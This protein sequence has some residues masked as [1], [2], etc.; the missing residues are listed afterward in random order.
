MSVIVPEKTPIKLND[1]LLDNL[2]VSTFKLKDMTVDSF[3]LDRNLSF[4]D[5]EGGSLVFEMNIKPSVMEIVK[6]KIFSYNLVFRNPITG[7]TISSHVVSFYEDFK[8]IIDVGES[9]HQ[10][11]IDEM[12]KPQSIVVESSLSSAA[13]DPPQPL[14]LIDKETS[15]PL[16]FPESSSLLVDEGLDPD[17][18][19]Q[20]SMPKFT[21][22]S[23][24]YSLD[25]SGEKTVS[26]YRLQK[27]KSYTTRHIGE[28][29]SLVSLRDERLDQITPKIKSPT[30][31]SHESSAISALPEPPVDSE[32]VDV[33]TR[34]E[35]IT[36][37]FDS[38]RIIEIPKNK[39][40][41]GI[42]DAIFTPIVSSSDGSA[43]DPDASVDLPYE[44]IK[45]TIRLK[46]S[47]KLPALLEPEVP[48][49]ILIRSNTPGKISYSVK[50]NDPTTKKILVTA[51]HLNKYTLT[52]LP[53]SDKEFVF[54]F[55]GYDGDIK[56]GVFNGCVNKDPYAVLLIAQDI[57]P[58]GTGLASTGAIAKSFPS[59]SLQDYK[60]NFVSV[61]A[62]LEPE[63]NVRIEIDQDTLQQ[64]SRIKICRENLSVPVSSL[65]RTK[66]LLDAAGPSKTFTHLD[67]TPI[68]NKTYRYY[69]VSEYSKASA[70]TVSATESVVSSSDSII[71]V[72]KEK[73]NLYNVNLARLGSRSFRPNASIKQSQ[74]SLIETQLAATGLSLENFEDLGTTKNDL[75]KLLYFIV[76]RLDRKSGVR[77]F[78]TII[79]PNE[80]YTDNSPQSLT[81]Y[82]Y[83]FRLAAAN[84]TA[85]FVLDNIVKSKETIDSSVLNSYVNILNESL[86]SASGVIETADTFFTK[87]GEYS[88]IKAGLTSIELAYTVE[89]N[90]EVSAP[91]IL[92][93]YTI[94]EGY[95]TGSPSLKINWKVSSK[96]DLEKIDC[97]YVYCVYQGSATV[98]Q[99]VNCSNSIGVYGY[100]D[101]EYFNEI[102]QKEYYV[103]S[104]YKDYTFGPK[105]DSIFRTKHA[106][107][108]MKLLSTSQM[109]LPALVSAKKKIV[110]FKSVMPTT[111]SVKGFFGG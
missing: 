57:A 69:A 85:S 8:N 110:P 100:V 95:V 101:T 2:S 64:A 75:K 76:E 83:I 111:V 19:A 44:L 106:P 62:F 98:M 26:E 73:R 78:M 24:A 94:Y 33:G 30:Y 96:A 108:P 41:G 4:E 40:E 92:S 42:V 1:I 5:Q 88:A 37:Y 18:V 70:S 86:T 82:T 15:E 53:E 16:S 34:I 31:R 45:S 6:N 52:P 84:A 20:L 89:P 72:L 11:I 38:K 10:A 104:R 13:A 55:D 22:S 49:E 109:V 105:S 25:G 9:D 47:N 56:N 63:G 59:E 93:A 65:D 3:Y 17:D 60:T 50:R 32:T 67:T 46:L 80:I 43:E 14:I 103:I 91:K 107:V 97:F 39:L 66:I 28:R 36:E 102:G 54:N 71:K 81:R 90:L 48:P 51:R 27:T 29:I 23:S 99:T 77:E 74:A 58:D 7:L 35:F 21:V 61:N 68:P 12:L 79:R 87:S